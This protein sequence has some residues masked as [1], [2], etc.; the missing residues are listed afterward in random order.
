MEVREDFS[1]EVTFRLI[2]ECTRGRGWRGKERAGIKG[3]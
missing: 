1:E 3:N 2:D